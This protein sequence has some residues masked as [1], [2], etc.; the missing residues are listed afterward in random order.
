[1]NRQEKILRELAAKHQ[2]SYSHAKEIFHLI[3][4]CTVK[5]ISTQDKRD[6]DNY[7]IEEKFKTIHIDNFGKFIPCP[8]YIKNANNKLK[9]KNSNEDKLSK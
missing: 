4:Q 1:M 6:K 3:I 8:G 9:L 2:I 5:T 7:Y